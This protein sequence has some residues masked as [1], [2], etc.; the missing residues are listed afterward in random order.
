M[1]VFSYQV[2]SD[3]I[4][5]SVA[6]FSHRFWSLLDMIASTIPRTRPFSTMVFSV[7]V[8]YKN[9]LFHSHSLPTTCFTCFQ[10]VFSICAYPVCCDR[11]TWF[12]EPLGFQLQF[13]TA[14]TTTP[15][16]RHCGFLRGLP[17]SLSSRSS[18]HWWRAH[19]TTQC[20]PT[21]YT[22]CLRWHI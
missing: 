13:H 19:E 17:F 4:S 18:Y 22:W 15:T 10:R 1:H 20:V 12:H 2:P 11:M 3:L 9:Y 21:F 7:F 5:P 14:T 8:T 6:P 16:N